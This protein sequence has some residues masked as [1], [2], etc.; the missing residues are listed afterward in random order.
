MRT[1]VIGAASGSAF[2]QVANTQVVVGVY[3]PRSLA[4]GRE[5][6]SELGQLFCDVKLAPF[7]V[8]GARREA[9]QGQDEAALSA[10]L[11]RALLASVQLERFPKSVLDVY[12]LVLESDGGTLAATITAASLALADAGVELFD[13]VPACAVAKSGHRIV[14]D[15]TG[16]EERFGQAQLTAA[17]MPARDEVTH[18]VQTGELTH[19]EA[20]EALQ[21][22]FDGCHLVHEM[23][24]ACLLQAGAAAGEPL[25]VGVV[26]TAGAA[27][28]PAAMQTA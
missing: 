1:G 3:G 27:A 26:A 21:L 20:A 8:A 18:V 16:A 14:V 19:D 10:V 4:L 9:G 13:L 5:E 6:F 28:A 23:M 11:E 15:P 2:V 7:A 22:A 25:E 24:R 17:L 12:A